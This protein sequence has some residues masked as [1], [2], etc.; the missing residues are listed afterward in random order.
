VISSFHGGGDVR[1]LDDILSEDTNQFGP[2]T[3][4]TISLL[5]VLMVMTFITAWLYRQEIDKRAKVEKELAAHRGGN[6]RLAAD[7]FSAADFKKY[8]V[9]D[10]ENPTATFD[11]VG[12]IVS[13][14]QRFGNEY[15]WIFV[16]GHSSRLDDRD[17][18]DRS[19]AARRDRNWNYAGRR[20]TVIAGLLQ[21]QLG[22][23]R[24]EKLVVVNTGELDLKDPT[25]PTAQENAWVEVVF[26]KEW[27]RPSRN[28]E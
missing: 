5:A 28:R 14:Y 11:T 4:L 3:D 16:I 23:D 2:G 13:E 12:R 25:H 17:A 24:A 19:P 7:F 9:T 21:Q 6:F 22:D 27:K 20:A 8:P 26:G 10:L 18:R 1:K 15:P